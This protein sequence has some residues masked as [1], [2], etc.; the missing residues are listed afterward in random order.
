MATYFMFLRKR[1][2]P[3]IG[4]YRSYG[5]V[6][7]ERIIDGPAAI[8]RDVTPDGD[9]AYRMVEAFNR[10]GLSTIHLLDVV[11]DMLE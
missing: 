11:L 2:A 8:I 4:A 9:L 10:L 7:Y 5:I 1:S 6:A 3:E